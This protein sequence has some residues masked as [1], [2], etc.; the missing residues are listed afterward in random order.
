[1]TLGLSVGANAAMLELV[2]VLMFRTPAH[3]REPGR[4]VSVESAENDVRYQ[5]L[6]ERLQSLELAAYTRQTLGLWLLGATVFGL[7]GTLAVTLAAIGIYGALAFSIRQRTV[8]IG[9]RMALG[10]SAG[11]VARMVIKRGS[12]LLLA[13]MAIGLTAAVIAARLLARQVWNVSPFDPLAFAGVSAI[14]LVAGLQACVW[15][16]R[17]AARIDPIVAL[18]DE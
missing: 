5:D 3:A 8:E 9:V 15:P 11:S 16:A 18:R 10:A 2:D 6:R 1:M 12:W 13:G 4:I 7:F 17:R 14:L